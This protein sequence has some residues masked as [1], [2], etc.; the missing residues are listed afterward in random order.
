MLLDALHNKLLLL[1]LLGLQSCSLMVVLLLDGVTQ[2]GSIFCV[3]VCV[4]DTKPKMIPQ[5]RYLPFLST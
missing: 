2:D 5:G 4:F 3:C 1:R